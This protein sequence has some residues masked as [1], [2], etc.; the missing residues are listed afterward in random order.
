[1]VFASKVD[2]EELEMMLELLS[3]EEIYEM[4]AGALAAEFYGA[5]FG[6]VKKVDANT[7]SQTFTMSED[8]VTLK[9]KMVMQLKGGNVI[10]GA[11]VATND[12]KFNLMQA[13]FDTFK[14][15]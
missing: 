3:I 2:E 15:K 8:G 11:I 10:V 12:A 4:M 13:S 9:G 5:D 6:A 7:V 1:M 14:A